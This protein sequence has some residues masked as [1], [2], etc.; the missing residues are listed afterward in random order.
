MKAE[1]REKIAQAMSKLTGAG[2]LPNQDETL[3]FEPMRWR[4]PHIPFLEWY[5]AQPSDLQ[6]RIRRVF[7]SLMVKFEGRP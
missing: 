4:G 2:D 3:G 5:A 7:P 1:D 6:D